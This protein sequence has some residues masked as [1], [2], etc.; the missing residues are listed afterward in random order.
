MH[1]TLFG[2]RVQLYVLCNLR[3][4]SARIGIYA[5]KAGMKGSKGQSLIS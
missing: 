2:Q 1:V 5:G 3:G 4:G